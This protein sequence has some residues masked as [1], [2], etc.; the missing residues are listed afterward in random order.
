MRLPTRLREDPILLV[1]TVV[2]VVAVVVA[3]ALLAWWVLVLTPYYPP[4]PCAPDAHIQA[5]A[6]LWTILR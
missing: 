4:K 3:A 5:K 1:T 6:I 2:M